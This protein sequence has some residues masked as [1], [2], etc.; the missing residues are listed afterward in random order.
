MPRRATPG[1]DWRWTAPPSRRA[2]SRQAGT[3]TARP[4]AAR[5][6]LPC[7]AAAPDLDPG[8]RRRAGDARPAEPCRTAGAGART[9][10]RSRLRCAAGRA[11]TIRGYAR[12]RCRASSRRA[13][14]ATSSPMD[15]LRING[16]LRQDLAVLLC[17]PRRGKR[18]EACRRNRHCTAMPGLRVDC[19]SAPGAAR[20][21]S[22]ALERRCL[23]PAQLQF[24]RWPLARLALV[25]DLHA[26]LRSGCRGKW[27]CPRPRAP[28]TP[29]R[30][31][32]RQD[33]D[34][35]WASRCRAA[36]ECRRAE[37]AETHGNGGDDEGLH[38]ARFQSCGL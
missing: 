14:C 32:C 18:K 6:G 20:V 36:G 30:C 11:D 3:A 35:R 4:A 13:A 12:R 29:D 15:L 19:L 7:A 16:S 27:R 17:H 1:C 23:I 24:Q 8:R 10:G 37:K 25:L 31:R 38:L 9:A 28:L 5:R 34:Q 2:S 22:G 21:A 33:Q 26:P